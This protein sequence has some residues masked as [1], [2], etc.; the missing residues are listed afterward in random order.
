MNIKNS[1]ETWKKKVT[2]FKKTKPEMTH[3]YNNTL[4]EP[5]ECYILNEVENVDGL[6]NIMNYRGVTLFN[7]K[8]TDLTELL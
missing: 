8:L 6:V 5:V 7:I 2:W 4:G 1:I 3:T